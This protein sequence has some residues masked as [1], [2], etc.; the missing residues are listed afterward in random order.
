MMNKS[1]PMSATA[2]AVL[3]LA[4]TSNDHLVQLPHMPV[5]AARQ[6]VRSMLKAGLVEELPALVDDARYKWR[7]TE[8]GEVLGLRATALGLVRVA[9]GANAAIAA[10]VSIGTAGEAA[11]EASL[12]IRIR[13]DS[14]STT[15][16]PPP[17]D[18]P[19]D[20]AQASMSGWTPPTLDATNAGGIALAFSQAGG[21]V[22]EPPVA[23][24]PARRRRSK[25][26][27]WATLRR[28][29]R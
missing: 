20:A 18:L 22:Q 19:A 13:T 25:L 11:A 2:R 24:E 1:K 5:A 3:T 16:T 12:A 28:Q 8:N 26:H 6:V 15:V 4:A 29:Q 27:R 14:P 23:V 7:T 17:E 21:T 9:E 10:S